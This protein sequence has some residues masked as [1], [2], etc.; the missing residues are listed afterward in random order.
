MRTRILPISRVRQSA[1][2]VS[3]A[4]SVA[5]T[6]LQSVVQ[7]VTSSMCMAAIPLEWRGGSAPP[8][9]NARFDRVDEGTT[10]GAGARI[11]LLQPVVPFRLGVG[12]VD[13]QERRRVT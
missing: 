9:Q 5:C 10:L 2:P 8:A 11:F 12:I 3:P 4:C 7:N 1:M 6:V 13:Q